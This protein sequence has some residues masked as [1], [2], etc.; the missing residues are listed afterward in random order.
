VNGAAKFGLCRAYFKGSTT[1][2][3]HKH[4][5]SKAFKKLEAAATARSETVAA[6]CADAKPGSSTAG[7][8]RQ[9]PPTTLAKHSDVNDEGAPPTSLPN[10]S[11][12][13]GPPTS[14]P[15]QSSVHGLGT[16]PSSV[17]GTGVADG[18]SHDGASLNG[19]TVA[20]TASDGRSAKGSDNAGTHRP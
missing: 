13:H 4:K 15:N 7:A 11:G 6:F 12:V 8:N 17:G 3:A 9:G 18:N 14:L 16:P 2:T 5:H 20:G 1:G 19:T 10:Q